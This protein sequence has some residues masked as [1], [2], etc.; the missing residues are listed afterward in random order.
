MQYEWD[1]QKR[2]GNV[3]KH[4]IDFQDAVR[5]FEGGTLLMEDDRLDYG[6]RRFVSLGLLQGRVI[7]VVHVEQTGVTRIISARKAT[8]YEQRI[9]LEGIA[10]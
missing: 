9:Y 10:D 8:K 7:V 2:L 5:I 3:R 4:R 1:E 6:E